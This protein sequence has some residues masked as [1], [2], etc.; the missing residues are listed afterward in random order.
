M[1]KTQVL[2]GSVDQLQ[3]EIDKNLING[4]QECVLGNKPPVDFIQVQKQVSFGACYEQSF[5]ISYILRK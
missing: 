4:M 5:I 3:M 1:F 2:P